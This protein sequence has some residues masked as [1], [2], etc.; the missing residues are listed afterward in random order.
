MLG[1]GCG[2]DKSI[3]S[4]WYTLGLTKLYSVVWGLNASFGE[5]TLSQHDAPSQPQRDTRLYLSDADCQR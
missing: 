4:I 3:T 2:N 1:S 5:T